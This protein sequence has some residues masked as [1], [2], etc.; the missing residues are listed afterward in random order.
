[1]GVA[2]PLAIGFRMVV[3]G[4][5]DCTATRRQVMIAEIRALGLE[6]GGAPLLESTIGELVVGACGCGHCGTVKQLE[7]S[8]CRT[9]D[10]GVMQGYR[11]SLGRETCFLRIKIRLPRL[12]ARLRNELALRGPRWTLGFRWL[13]D[14]GR[15]QCGRPFGLDLPKTLGRLGVSRHLGYWELRAL[16]HGFLAWLR[17]QS[18]GCFMRAALEL[19]FLVA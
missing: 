3:S 7:R 5:L 8:G 10:P 9:G 11:E 4:M 12:N 19:R 14:V 1:M 13:C 6:F 17:P 16:K 18:I 15:A 2:F